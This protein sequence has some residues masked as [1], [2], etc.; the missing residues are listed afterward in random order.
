MNEKIETEHTHKDKYMHFFRCYTNES[1]Y[2]WGSQL[3]LTRDFV[4]SCIR[5]I[6]TNSSLTDEKGLTLP[7]V[8]MLE[9]FF[10]TYL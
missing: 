2:M 10:I 8:R 1:Q 6:A 3:H 9:Y 7:L 5:N 4:G